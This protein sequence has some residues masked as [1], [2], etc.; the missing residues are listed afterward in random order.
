MCLFTLSE[1]SGVASQVLVGTRLEGVKNNLVAP[2]APQSRFFS[3][4]TSSWNCISGLEK[5]R[6]L[7]VSVKFLISFFGSL[8]F[9]PPACAYALPI[10]LSS[11]LSN[12]AQDGTAFEVKDPRRLE[13]D[14]LPKYFRHSR[15]QSLV[16]QLNFYSFK[17]ISKVR[18]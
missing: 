10:R 16:R 8:T 11:L 18:C 1:I 2:C 3:A 14:I 7:S 12:V 15:F 6:A 17:K 13:Q 5:M 9:K 4:P